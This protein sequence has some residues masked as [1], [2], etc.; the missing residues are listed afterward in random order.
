MGL[1]YIEP[2]KSI[3][4]LLLVSLS[5]LFTFAIWNYS[6]N[7]EPMEKLQTVDISISEKK[8]I[9]EIIKPYKIITNLKDQILGS[10][11]TEKIDR[12]LTEMNTWDLSDL[13][14]VRQDMNKFDIAQ[15]LRQPSQMTF[16]FTGEVPMQVYDN[17][18]LVDDINIPEASFNRLIIDWSQSTQAPVIHLLSEMSGLH[19]QMQVTL[20]NKTSFLRNVVDVGQ[21]FDEYTEIDRGNAPFLAVPKDPIIAIGKTYYQEEIKPLRF[22]DALFSDPNA[23]RRNQVDSTHEEYGD[24]HAFMNIDTEIKRLNY[25]MPAVESQ[26]FMLPSELLL[27]TIDFINEHGGWTDEFRYAYMNPYSRYV[28]FQL[29]VDGLPVFSDQSGMS[30]ITETWGDD[31]VFKYIRPYYTLDVEIEQ[32]QK[33]LELPSGVEVA[34]ALRESEELDFDMI[35]EITPG[36]YMIHDIDDELIILQ[37]CWYYLIKDNWLRFTPE[38]LQGGGMIGLE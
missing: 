27:N 22:R 19:Y 3:V 23:V 1:K 8:T 30:E 36:Y 35:E 28:R 6:P 14:L 21:S 5:V 26:D 34:N 17:V 20:P 32:E 31:R 16:Y 38:E 4:L 15:I 13:E 9:D 33:K 18:L 11:D 37:P 24:D 29:Y 25:V 2:I 12:I 7:Y 10:T